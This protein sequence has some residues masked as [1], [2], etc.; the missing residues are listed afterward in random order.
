MLSGC[1]LEDVREVGQMCPPTQAFCEKALDTPLDRIWTEQIDEYC[2]AAKTCG[3]LGNDKSECKNEEA[4]LCK[5]YI[6]DMSKFS[7]EN[8]NSWPELAN[9]PTVSMHS[10]ETCSVTEPYCIWKDTGLNEIQLNCQSA[11]AASCIEEGGVLCYNK[12]INPKTSSQYCGA[13]DNCSEESYTDCT[14]NLTENMCVAGQCSSSCPDGQKNC[15]GVCL[16]W[17]SNHVLECPDSQM[18]CDA[19]YADCDGDAS[20]GCESAILRDSAHC[21]GCGMACEDGEVCLE[22]ACVTNH[23]SDSLT[24]CATDSGNQCMDTK[25]SDINHCGACGYM[26]PAT[27]TNAT[28]KGCVAGQCE[29]ECTSPYTNIGSA[30]HTN[31]VDLS[32]DHKNCGSIGNICTTGAVCLDGQCTLV[33]CS[34]GLT[35]CATDSGN[36]CID[37]GG[38]DADNCGTC[39]Y[40]CSEHPQANATS[41]VCLDGRCQYECE[42]DYQNAGTASSPNCVDFK[43]DNKHCG[44]KGNACQPGQVCVD[45]KCITNSCTGN[46]TLCATD[47]G[48]I[49]M[50]V[51]GSDANNCGACGYQCSEH[52]KL[53]AR[54]STCKEGKCQYTCDVGYV[55]S[56]TE[57]SPICVNIMSDAKN[58]GALGLNCLTVIENSAEV[59]CNNSLCSVTSCKESYHKYGNECEKDDLTNCGTHG[60]TCS[61]SD[62]ANSLIVSC[63]TGKCMA[64]ACENGY[65]PTVAGKCKAQ[66]VI[67]ESCGS[68]LY[69][70]PESSAQAGACCS[71]LAQCH[72]TG[73]GKRCLM[74]IAPDL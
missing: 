48:N 60:V 71:T 66:T 21:G 50:D 44:S 26:C 25:G 16:E 49:C 12:C 19:D 61:K 42:Y 17:S 64:K 35:L 9:I 29:Y 33:N 2:I 32:S 30:T 6:C 62:V 51:N 65:S 15:Q 13:D 24:L 68:S 47:S 28:L 72:E 53:N 36:Q 8:G 11:I 67:D 46:L 69:K 40:Q 22:G 18:I 14:K 4:L 56:G 39:G 73:A 23:C 58:C 57:I 5:R 59:S 52:S 55:N 43:T 7:G 27:Q 63:D 34:G 10:D 45:G 54:S 41:N 38:T 74:Q 20:N 37:L 1:T 31:C 3:I 70:C